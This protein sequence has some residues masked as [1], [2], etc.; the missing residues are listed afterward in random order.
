MLQIKII[1]NVK[2]HYT[3]CS[4]P[5]IKLGCS[6][7]KADRPHKGCC[8]CIMNQLRP[9]A[10]VTAQNSELIIGR[11]KV[12]LA[13]GHSLMDWI[14]LGRSGDLSGVGSNKRIVTPAEL[15]LHNTQKDMW[16]CLRGNSIKF[17]HF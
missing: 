6:Q 7:A 3:P 13:P 4:R 16:M 5:A 8:C 2:P 10:N 12:T 17:L 15:A 9:S 14:R 11:K 1:R